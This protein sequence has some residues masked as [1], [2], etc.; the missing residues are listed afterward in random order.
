VP[1]RPEPAAAVADADRRLRGEIASLAPQ[2]PGHPDLYVLAIAG[3]GSERVFLNEVRHLHDVAERRLD[4]LGRVLVLANH[5]AEPPWR[6]PVPATIATIRSALAGIGAAMDPAEDILLLYVTTHGS[7]EHWLLLRRDGV[8]DAG[9]DADSLR[10]ALDDAGIRHRVLALS[11]C[12]AGG[13]APAL[14]P[15]DT[16][17]LAAARADRTS[18]GCGNDSVATFFGRAWLVDGLNATVDFAAAFRRA[19]AAIAEREA[20]R[21]YLPSRPQ[22][23]EGERIGAR[24]A[25]WRNGFEPG[26]PV[27]YPHAEPT[28]EDLAATADDAGDGPDVVPPLLPFAVLEARD[29]V[30]APARPGDG[31]PSKP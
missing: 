25:A 4:A 17:V 16:L 28:P 14:Q 8:D 26:A 18:F 2:R 12:Y 9:L 13:L 31:R 7:D 10:D 1:A 23:R 22:I 6:A 27:P 19:R 11:A 5:P 24:L 30:S 29:A 20:A 3:D 15:P 21:D